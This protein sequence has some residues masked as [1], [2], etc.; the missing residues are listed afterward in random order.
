ME[1]PLGP[2]ADPVLPH[3][4]RQRPQRKVQHA[5]RLVAV[6][7]GRA[8]SPPDQ[9]GFDPLELLSEARDPGRFLVLFD[10]LEMPRR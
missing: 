5:G 1:L 7:P 6:P 8:E 2:Q 10:A 3:L 9:I 4:A